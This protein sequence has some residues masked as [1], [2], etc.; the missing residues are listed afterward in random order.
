ME[1][2][3]AVN[4]FKRRWLQGTNFRL[5][6]KPGFYGGHYYDLEHLPSGSSV[7]F[8]WE[9]KY[10][11]ISYGHTE[12]GHTRQYIGTNLRALA[13][14]FAIEAG[15][16]VHQTGCGNRCNGVPISTRILR[17]KLGWSKNDKGFRFNSVFKP[18]NNNSKVRNWL[19][20]RGLAARSPNNGKSPSPKR[21]RV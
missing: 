10:I 3:T 6:K 13:T 19:K 17:Q 4:S 20:T 5:V 18:G 21:Q 15:K 9:P 2:N 7:A 12:N 11:Y 16:V 1:E 8:Q 14:I